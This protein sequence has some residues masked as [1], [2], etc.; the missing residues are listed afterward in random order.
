MKGEHPSMIDDARKYML[1]LRG[2]ILA[3]EIDALT[4]LI[5]C[6][7][8]LFAWMNDRLV[9]LTGKLM[10]TCRALGIDLGEMLKAEGLNLEAGSDPVWD[11]WNND[12]GD[13]E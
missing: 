2:L 13:Q 10:I 12:Q 1:M 11:R 7:A 8:S 3:K 4:F 9:S 6:I 5:G